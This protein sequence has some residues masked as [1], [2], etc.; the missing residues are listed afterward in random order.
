MK[1]RRHVSPDE[2]AL[3]ESVAKQTDPLEGRPTAKPKKPIIPEPVHSR[4][5]IAPFQVGELST[6]APVALAKGGVKAPLNMDASSFAKL[7]RGKLRPERKIDLHGMTVSQA[8]PALISFLIDAFDDGKRLVL[9]ITGKGDREDPRGPFQVQR[10]VL[11]RQVPIWLSSAPLNGIILQS[12]A[13]HI[14]HG[15]EGALYIYLK[16]HR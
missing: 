8:H 11:R 7:K 14:R 5:T 9:V 6:S 3:W 12:V 15:G 4:Q 13:A 2:R 16:R 1:K 10:G